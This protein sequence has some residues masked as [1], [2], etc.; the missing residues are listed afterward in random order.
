MY[1]GW[2]QR[3]EF[4]KNKMVFTKIL[5]MVGTSL[6]W[7]PILFALFNSARRFIAIGRF[8]LDYLLPMELFPVILLGGGL[9]LWAVLRARIYIK[10]IAWGFGVSIGMLLF[11]QGLAV[12]L[13]LASGAAEATGWRLALVNIFVGLYS[14]SILFMGVGGILL[15]RD[16]F[17]E[18]KA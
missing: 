13:G 18:K 10:W 12:I 3:W 5:A 14:I 17:K 1:S 2:E 11:S 7:F 8:N 9:L 6:V 4:M 16:L 15:I